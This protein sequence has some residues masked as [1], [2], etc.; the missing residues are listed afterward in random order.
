MRKIFVGLA[1]TFLF[2][3]AAQADDLDFSKIKCKDFISAPKDQIGTIL[4]WLEGYYTK[5]NA[6]PILY[7]DK[8]VKDAKGLSA[9]CNA[10]NDDDII[11]AAEKV[12]PV[13]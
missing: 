8:I 3:S 13:K 1:A 4:T 6:P 10:H 9:Y 12:M 7:G 11:K 5:E 2:M